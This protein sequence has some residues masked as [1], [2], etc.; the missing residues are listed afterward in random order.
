[1]RKV[2]IV[3]ESAKHNYLPARKFG[4]VVVLFPPTYQ[5]AFDPQ[6]AIDTIHE[7]LVDIEEDDYLL[8]SGDPALI[9]LTAAVAS[10][11]LGGQV[12]LLKW[13]RQE[14]IYVPLNCSLYG[15]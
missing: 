3:Q 14:K 1:M 5:L 15:E 4:D 7:K 11:Y 8:L 10:D 6:Y 9:G 12:N 2:F 13:D